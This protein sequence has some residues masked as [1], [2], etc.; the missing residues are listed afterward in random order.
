MA[1]MAGGKDLA[2]LAPLQ[3]VEEEPKRVPSPN[4]SEPPKKERRGKKF[5][6]NIKNFLG[7]SVAVFSD[8]TS[9]ATNPIGS[10]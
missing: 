7:S 10:I 2:K 5:V 4:E 8:A 1:S 3:V 6:K 9:M